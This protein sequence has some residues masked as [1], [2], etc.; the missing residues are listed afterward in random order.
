MTFPPVVY[1]WSI[2]RNPPTGNTGVPGVVPHETPQVRNALGD[3]LCLVRCAATED[4][5][6]TARPNGPVAYGTVSLDSSDFG[7]GSRPGPAYYLRLAP[8]GGTQHDSVRL[9]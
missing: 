2:F 1:S 4:V 7:G 5:L 8:V 3:D 6:I 9:Q